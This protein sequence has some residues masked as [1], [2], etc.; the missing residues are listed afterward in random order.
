MSLDRRWLLKSAGLAAAT[1]AASPIL[2]ATAKADTTPTIPTDPGVSLLNLFASEAF[3]D[4][5]L[6]ALGSASSHTGEVGEVLRIANLINARTGNPSDPQTTDFDAYVEEFGEYSRHLAAAAHTAEANGHGV[7]ARNRYLRSS[8]YAAQ[9]LFFILG[10]SRGGKEE[11]MFRHSQTSWLAAMRLADPEFIEAEVDSPYG[12][13]PVYFLHSNVGKGPRHT[14]IISEGSDGQNVETMQLGV[15]AALAR[16]YNVVLFEGPGQMGPLFVWHVPF[17]A[18]W[19]LVI[20]PVLAW[21]RKQE[22]VEKVA[23]IGISFAGMLCARAA[24]KTAGLDAVVLDPGAYDFTTLWTDQESM[25]LVKETTDAS[26]EEKAGAREGLNKGFILEWPS[27]PRIQQFTIYKRGS[28]FDPQV[29][30][31][32]R[33]GTVVSDYYGL[34]EKMLPFRFGKDFQQISIPTLVTANEGDEFFGDQPEKAFSLL[35]S[36]SPRHKKLAYLTAQLGASLHD[37]PV[38]PQV[39]DEIIF[40]WLDEQ[41]A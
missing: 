4:E 8:Q 36:V 19:N 12:P 38:G 15:T 25:A 3:N 22:G 23:L 6:F 29:Q 26:P 21:A 30:R 35:H 14:V 7:T 39:A 41:L 37:Q 33:A 40:D 16:G 1:V 13:L 31:E 18:D 20:D 34:L 17:T 24:A 28:I 10:T 5:A 32:A 9:Q 2:A 27:M 11:A